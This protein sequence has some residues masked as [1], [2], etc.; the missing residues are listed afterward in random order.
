MI[1]KHGGI[2]P[3]VLGVCLLTSPAA[4]ASPRIPVIHR[5]AALRA[6]SSSQTGGAA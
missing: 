6:G 5:T 2:Q 1:K 3:L 4:L